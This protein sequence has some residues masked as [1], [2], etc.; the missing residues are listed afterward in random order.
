[1]GP[2]WTGVFHFIQISYYVD[3]VRIVLTQVRCGR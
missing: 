2:L 3:I 1:V